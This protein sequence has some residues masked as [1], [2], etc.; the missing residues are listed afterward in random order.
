MD[1]KS[2]LPDVGVTIFTVMTMLANEHGAINL[3]Q[4]FPDF[5]VS[6]QMV[7]LV[8]Q[9]MQKG[10][11]Q[12]A[13]M[14]GVLP[15]R[16]AIAGKVKKRYG[17]SYD[18]ATE[19]TVTSGATEAVFCAITAV[20]H[21]GDE[22]VILEPAYDAYVPVIRLCGGVPVF[23]ALT[24]PDYR[25]DWDAVRRAISSKTRLLVLNSPH[26]PSGSVL[27]P[28]DILA[29]KRLVSG[30]GLLIVSDEVYEHILFDGLSHESMACH[31][32]LAARSFVISSFGKTYHATG[33]KIGY[34]LAPA[35]LSREFQKIHQF[36]TF[37]SN[38]PVQ[39]AYAEFIKD[40][41][42][43]LPLAGFYQKK[44]DLFLELIGK[45]RFRPIA[46]RGTYFQMLDYSA[47]SE[48]PDV[49]FARRLTIEH[50]VAAIPP[51]VFHH[52]GRDHKALRFCF[53]KKDD[54][55]KEAAEKLCRI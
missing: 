33:W 10:H 7:D 43:Y 4:G 28:E 48:E 41:S 52:D 50:G 26:N 5:D 49:V 30:S 15:L 9:Y 11:N 21:P 51:S 44:R 25:I 18:P 6:P 14:Q 27:L 23:V 39:C 19:I 22:V 13:P 32:E 46:C 8:R 2:K 1:M 38:T 36:V 16:E 45:S 17:A 31:P 55:L 20:V 29:L 37:A 24:Y 42:S 3:S 12:Y 53:A 35:V 40:E 34:C 47:I 54:T